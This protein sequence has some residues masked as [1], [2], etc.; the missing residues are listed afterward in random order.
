MLTTSGPSMCEILYGLNL[1]F[2]AGWGRGKWGRAAVME[3]LTSNQ[4]PKDPRV[5]HGSTARHAVFA[6]L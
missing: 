1:A 4:D 2:G 3:L 5:D 6:S